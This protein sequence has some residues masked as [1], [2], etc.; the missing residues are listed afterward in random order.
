MTA[1]LDELGVTDLVSSIPGLAAVG[2]AP[3]LAE[4]GDPT[5]FATAR[6]LVKHA[7]LAPRGKLSGSFAGRSK[8]TGQCRARLPLAAW[9]SGQPDAP[10]PST[11]TATAA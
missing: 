3:H 2:A 11:P 1:V 8:L 10:T 9:R 4:T 7:G 6:A 5:R